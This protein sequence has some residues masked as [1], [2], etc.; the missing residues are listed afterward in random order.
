MEITRHFPSALARLALCLALLF[1]TVAHSVVQAKSSVMPVST[2][3]STGGIHPDVLSAYQHSLVTEIVKV[4]G[5]Q[6]Q[7]DSS[8]SLASTLFTSENVGNTE[9]VG[10]TERTES[11]KG[12]ESTIGTN[13]VKFRQAHSKRLYTGVRRTPENE[14]Q[15]YWITPIAAFSCANNTIECSNNMGEGN[16]DVS[17][18]YLALYNIVEN[19]ELAESLSLT[20][21][22]FKASA[23]YQELQNEISAKLDSPQSVFSFGILSFV[24]NLHVDTSNLWIISDLVPLFSQ[25][26]ERNELEGLAADFVREVLIDAEITSPILY[27]PW[28]RIA[29][30]ATTKSNVLVFSIVLTAE[31]EPIFHWITPISRNLH[32]FFGINQGTF[33]K[34][35]DVPLKTRVGTLKNDYRF[36]VAASRGFDAKAYGSWPEMVEAV[37]KNEV[38]VIFGSQGAVDFGCNGNARCSDIQQVAPYNVSSTYLALSKLD[39]S[40]VL[41]EKLKLASARIK[42]SNKFKQTSQAWSEAVHNNHNVAHHIENGVVHLWKKQK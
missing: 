20:A 31:R 24:G 22:E 35:D 10:N 11:T 18:S 6:A 26:G 12:I 41:V 16:T 19:K 29:K 14:H 32:G 34:I 37:L 23:S 17:L 39:T 38:D 1:Y 8:L 3:E 30:E 13:D 4:A 2:V 27:A 36:D 33:E 9:S 42:K 40:L 28:D 25:L 7:F 5:Y 15:Y 21:S